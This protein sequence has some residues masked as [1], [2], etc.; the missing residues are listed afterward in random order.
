ML[1]YDQPF[2]SGKN[3]G[4][5]AN[6]VFGF[7]ASCLATGFASAEWPAQPSRRGAG[8]GGQSVRRG[9]RNSRVLIY[10]TPLSKTA[11]AGSGDT[12]ADLVLGQNN[13]FD[14]EPPQ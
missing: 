4:Q 13:R 3:A 12:T 6:L 8:R 5:A 11:L 14:L 1:E 2:T 7:G 9:H 10:L